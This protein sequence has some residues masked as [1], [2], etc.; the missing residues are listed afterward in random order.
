MDQIAFD[1]YLPKFLAPYANPEH[2]DQ[3]LDALQVYTGNL[4]SNFSTTFQNMK[5][6]DLLATPY[7][8]PLFLH[9]AFGNG[10]IY[11]VC[12]SILAA[13]ARR[14]LF[15]R[16][17]WVFSLIFNFLTTVGGS[18][19]SAY[20]LLQIPGWMQ[21]NISLPMVIVV[22]YLV[23]FSPFDLF[24]KLANTAPFSTVFMI[25]QKISTV[26]AVIAGIEMAV[27]VVPDS[28]PT[29]L[30]IGTLSGFGGV[31]LGNVVTKSIDDPAYSTELSKPTWNIKSAFFL[32]LTYYVARDP[33]NFF[34]GPLCSEETI[35]FTLL[36]YMILHG[37]TSS[38]VGYFT[39]FPIRQIESIFFF[40]T[41]I[42]SVE[43]AGASGKISAPKFITKQELHE[44]AQ[45]EK[46]KKDPKSKANKKH[47]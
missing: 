32:A 43:Q 17:Y 7:E 4:A 23:H 13:A 24:Y 14:N 5:Y 47:Q 15:R 38:L 16:Q 39:P 45:K 37:L 10:F 27:A 31:L 35:R 34:W 30:V 11:F 22:W 21:D 18:T 19:V 28:V 25:G 29:A 2:W 33:R 1:S 44:V 3:H 40:L 42:P 20:M 12:H 26:R 9:A 8:N 36:G 41:R 46:E 6:G